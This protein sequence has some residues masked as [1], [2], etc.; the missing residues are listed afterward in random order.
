[1]NDIEVFCNYGIA[2]ENI[3]AIE[4]DKDIYDQ[5]VNSLTEK[6]IHVKIHR[7]SLSEFFELTNHEFDIVY[8]DACSPIISQKLSPLETLKQIFINK[9][10]TGLSVLITNF[11]EPKENL[12]WGDILA[13][14]FATK[15]E[16]NVP[17]VDHN[18][19][20]D[21]L[22]KSL[23]LK[24]YS[25]YI[26]NH[27]ESYYDLY[28]TQFISS[29]GS[30][31]VPFWQIMS[32]SS[33]QNNYLLNDSVFIQTLNKIK[34]SSVGGSNLKEFI[35]N[36][37]HYTL[38]VDTY[39]LLNW[40]RFILELFPPNHTLRQ[41]IESKRKKI[42]LEDAI[43]IGTLLKN[44]EEGNTGF[45]TFVYDVCNDRLKGIL[46]DLDFFDRDF[47]I[48]CDIPMKNLIVELLFGLYGYPYIANVNKNLA[49]KYKAKETWMYSNVFVFDQCRY[50]YD[51]LPS[52]DL[53]RS[54]FERIENQVII[55][56]C[57]DGIHRNHLEINSDLFK[58][59]LI[60]G[61]N[62][63][64]NGATLSGRININCLAS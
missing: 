14:W 63:E 42:S 36:T 1:M 30:E 12:N 19:H 57:I 47:R 62:K 48:T 40:V 29:L 31:I 52:V 55:R 8:Y 34:D 4:G 7:G 51:F 33:V 28:L 16:Y 9:R 26:N 49:L 37:P 58:W 50:L 39:P 11:S 23:Y 18:Y 60:E 46:V 13:S 35:E 56:G 20:E 32:M 2:L 64:F 43:Y 25:Q 3:W 38:S 15:E 54:F 59:G 22:S 53:F 24:K 6:N 27:L 41:F 44:I 21:V 61:I 17:A 45:K 10:L 5:A